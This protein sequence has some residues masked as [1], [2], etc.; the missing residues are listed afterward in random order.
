MVWFKDSAYASD[1]WDLG[2]YPRKHVF[3]PK[4]TILL[5]GLLSGRT[6]IRVPKWA[7]SL[8]ELLSF[9]TITQCSGGVVSMPS[10]RTFE[11]WAQGPSSTR[12]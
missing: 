2:F 10:T 11:P 3:K 6:I 12:R 5:I 1:D 8:I 9:Q 7:T 4:T